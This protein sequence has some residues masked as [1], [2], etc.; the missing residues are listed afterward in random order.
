MPIE[1]LFRRPAQ[2]SESNLKLME[3]NI[4]GQQRSAAE[5]RGCLYIYLLW[6]IVVVSLSPQQSVDFPPRKSRANSETTTRRTSAMH[7]K[8]LLCVLIVRRARVRPPNKRW[9]AL[10]L[11]FYSAGETREMQTC[12]RRRH[13]TNL[14]FLLSRFFMGRK[15]F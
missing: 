5:R 13:H 15:R 14:C 6:C 3:H 9:A 10:C 8:E 7:F 4:S 2:P 1:S 12:K 11:F